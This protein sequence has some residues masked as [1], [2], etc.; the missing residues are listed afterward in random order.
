MSLQ[1]TD[2]LQLNAAVTLKL[3]SPDAMGLALGAFGTAGLR[4]QWATQER[5][6]E[7]PW[8]GNLIAFDNE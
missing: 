4:Y 2:H 8:Q 3:S 7:L 6:P 5:R 1:L